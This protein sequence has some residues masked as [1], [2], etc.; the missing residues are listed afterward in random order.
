[1]TRN[2]LP[3]DLP[4]RSPFVYIR[5]LGIMVNNIQSRSLL[6]CISK[7]KSSIKSF[8]GLCSFEELIHIFCAQYS[9]DH[10]W[11]GDRGWNAMESPGLVH[12]SRPMTWPV[13]EHMI[14]PTCMM[15]VR[16]WTRL[17]ILCVMQVFTTLKVALMQTMPSTLLFQV[18]Q[19]KG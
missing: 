11:L 10:I 12:I 15:L 8:I 6:Q 17:G 18:E 2:Q 5:F 9:G 19:N 1:M 16:M 7:A 13:G 3:S 4:K 14:G